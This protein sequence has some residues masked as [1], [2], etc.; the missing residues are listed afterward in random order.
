MKTGYI[1]LAVYGTLRKNRVNHYLLQRGDVR[2]LGYGILKGWAYCPHLLTIK[3][4]PKSNNAFVVVEAYEIPYE[5]LVGPIDSLEGFPTLYDREKIT[6]SVVSKDH[7]EFIRKVTSGDT[8]GV[9]I[10]AQVY[11]VPSTMSEMYSHSFL[12]YEASILREVFG[13][14]VEVKDA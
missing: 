11:Y 7:R 10:E 3:K 12:D 13:E 9:E 2:F 8:K 1:N 4:L 6:V 14:I 5:L